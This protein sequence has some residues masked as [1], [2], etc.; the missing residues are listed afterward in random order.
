MNAKDGDV[1]DHINHIEWDN[2][3]SN[4]R[5]CTDHENVCNKRIAKNNKSGK[6]GVYKSK[7]KWRAVVFYNGKNI[8]LGTFD[9]FEKAVEAR[10]AKEIEMFGEFSPYYKKEG[11]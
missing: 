10:I 8:H 2:R 11:S 1:I 6:T 4:L 3:K 5:F 9:T 7:N